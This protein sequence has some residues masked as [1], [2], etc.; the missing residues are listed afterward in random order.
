MYQGCDGVSIRSD[1]GVDFIELGIF[2][3]LCLVECSFEGSMIFVS[4]S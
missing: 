4:I 2:S 1:N 3:R